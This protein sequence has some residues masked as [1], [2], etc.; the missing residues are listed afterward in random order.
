MQ[1][2]TFWVLDDKSLLFWYRSYFHSEDV[3]LCRWVHSTGSPTFAVWEK[4]SPQTPHSIVPDPLLT[5][6]IPGVMTGFLKGRKPTSA[7]ELNV[8]ICQRS[9]EIRAYTAPSFC[10]CCWR[11][12]QWQK[13]WLTTWIYNKLSPPLA[14]APSKQISSCFSLGIDL[15]PVRL[16]YPSWV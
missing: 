12:Q 2:H 15:F 13:R 10:W 8:S 4:D 5:A 3:W 14:A 16:G 1:S 6:N 11:V 7:P 9:D